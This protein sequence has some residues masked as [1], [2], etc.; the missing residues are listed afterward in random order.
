MTAL[1]QEELVSLEEYIAQNEASPVKLEY[2][3][4]R[5]FAM[6]GGSAAH[7]QIGFN[8]C[9]TL[10]SRLQGKRC[11]GASSDQKIRIESSD[12][13][14]YA[15]AV[16]VCPPERYSQADPHA[17]LNPSLLVEV[18]SPNT[19]KDDRGEKFEQY[20]R[21]PELHDYLLIAQD[22][23]LVEHFQRGLE[24]EWILRRFSEREDVVALPHLEIEIPLAEI[25]DGLDL[26]SGLTITRS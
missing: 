17:L 23:M 13:S 10:F 14:L 1:V 22:K 6:A 15:D 3:A 9:G 24:G 21:I 12:V 25:Y 4:G 19:E 20:S 5:V 26:P 16:V 11:R 2:W 18:L 8:I 7:A